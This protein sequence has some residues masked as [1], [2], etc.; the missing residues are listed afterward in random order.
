MLSCFGVITKHWNSERLTLKM[1]VKSIDDLAILWLSKGSCQLPNIDYKNNEILSFDFE[2]KDINV[3]EFI[4]V[5]RHNVTCRQVNA[6]QAGNF[7]FSR[8]GSVSK[9]VKF[10]EFDL[11]I[12]GQWHG[13][14]PRKL[15]GNL[16]CQHA[17]IYDQQHDASSSSSLFQVTLR[18]SYVDT[19]RHT[20]YTL[21]KHRSVLLGR[22]KNDR[23][24]LSFSS[25]A[26]SLY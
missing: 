9:T 1:E 20:Q 2:N 21:A 23:L 14:F 10:L 18:G 25:A 8:Y 13:R 12:K 11:E 7:D 4:D 5:R 22:C 15:G 3:E 16:H 19:P 24:N 6:R 26:L 17:Y